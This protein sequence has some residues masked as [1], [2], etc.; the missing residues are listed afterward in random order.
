L[1][2]DIDAALAQ[3]GQGTRHVALRLAQ[4][5][6]VLQLAGGVL[7]AQ[8]EQLAARGSQLLDEAGVV[9]FGIVYCIV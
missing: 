3:H 9:Q 7:E 1:G 2:V 8:P 5:G 4:T 6:A